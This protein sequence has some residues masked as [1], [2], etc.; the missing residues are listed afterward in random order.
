MVLVKTPQCRARL[1]PRL[2]QGLQLPGACGAHRGHSCSLHGLPPL[3]PTLGGEPAVRTEFTLWVALSWVA[4]C[5]PGRRW[6]AGR[7]P[8]PLPAPSHAHHGGL[9]LVTVCRGGKQERE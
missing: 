8:L 7:G 3:P 9:D 4:E 2:R 1:V 5:A 6:P